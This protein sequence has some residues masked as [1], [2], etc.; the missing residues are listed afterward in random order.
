MV[1]KKQ[2]EQREALAKAMKQNGSAMSPRYTERPTETDAEYIARVSKDPNHPNNDPRAFRIHPELPRAPVGFLEYLQAQQVEEFHTP[3]PITKRKGPTPLRWQDFTFD[4]LG[5]K[6]T[7][8][9]SDHERLG[10]W[11]D[12]W[13]TPTGARGYGSNLTPQR[14]FF[15][16]LAENGMRR[17]DFD[18]R[19]WRDRYFKMHREQYPLYKEHQKERAAVRRAARKGKK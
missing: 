18:W 17:E 13:S 12:Q 1:S 8:A 15:A 16:I 5:T 6:A 4:L 19:L 9:T 2:R 3:A 11:F 10:Y 14:I 7:N